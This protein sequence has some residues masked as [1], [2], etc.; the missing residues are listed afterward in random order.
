MQKYIYT[1]HNAITVQTGPPAMLPLADHS[2]F[3]PNKYIGKQGK[4]GNY[5][6]LTAQKCK[7]IPYYST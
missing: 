2:S 3:V 4:D 5:I 1:S 7:S 6:N